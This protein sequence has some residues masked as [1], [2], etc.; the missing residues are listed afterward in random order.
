[1]T[2]EPSL[3]RGS[4]TGPYG[5]PRPPR[6]GMRY[7]VPMA[8]QREFKNRKALHD[9]HVFEKVEAGIRLIGSEVK[10]IRD[11][12]LTLSDSYAK[13]E[14]G[15]V[16]LLNCHIAEYPNAGSFGHEPRRKRKLLLHKSEIRKLERRVE[17]TGYALVPLRVF[18]SP[19][20]FAKVELGICRGKQLHDKRESMKEREIDREI[21]REMSR[22]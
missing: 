8:S 12:N 9:F 3:A 13:I 19:R 7:N 2:G 21:E 15:Q 11:G 17:E 16:F 10:S 5:R 6:L 4:V 1:M 22:R 20:G 18:F 14:G